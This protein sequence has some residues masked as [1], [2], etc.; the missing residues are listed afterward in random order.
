MDLRIRFR[1]ADVPDLARIADQIAVLELLFVW[2]LVLL[3]ERCKL[4]GMPPGSGILSIGDRCVLC[5]RGETRIADCNCRLETLAFAAPLT[6]IALEG[7]F[8]IDLG[9]STS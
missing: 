7:V 2:A 8:A 3:V 4:G 5:V 6:P 1:S 9:E